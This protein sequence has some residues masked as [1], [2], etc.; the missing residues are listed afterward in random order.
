LLS[1][2]KDGKV[3]ITF[4]MAELAR[5]LNIG[6]TSLYRGLDALEQNGSISREKNTVYIRKEEK[7]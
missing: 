5:R 7:S 4:G 3:E 2:A 1:L 6:R